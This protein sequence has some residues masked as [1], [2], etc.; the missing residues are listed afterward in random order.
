MRLKQFCEHPLHLDEILSSK[1]AIFE[2]KQSLEAGYAFK[3]NHSIDL[4]LL[5]KYREYFLKNI[6]EN[7]EGYTPRT[8]GCKN[9]IQVHPDHPNQVVPAF[10]ISF[11][12]FPWNRESK[13]LFDELAKL[14]ILRNRLAS[15]PDDMYFIREDKNLTAR[16]A[17]QFYP[18]GKGYMNAHSDPKNI[19]QFAIPTL[20]LS[21]IN[22]DFNS[23][24]FFIVNEDEEKELMD[25]RLNFGDLS[26]FHTSIPHGVETIDQNDPSPKRGRLMAIAAVNPF[27]G[28][29]GFQAK[30]A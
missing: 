7:S 13:D 20:T 26:L 18:S 6:D 23:G 10:F 9:Y 2:L 4:D 25:K 19:H 29:D 12:I 16:I 15:L 24:G 28:V 17:M 11:S 22:S 27:S 5:K 8:P 30:N 1:N 14:F 21:K 3:I